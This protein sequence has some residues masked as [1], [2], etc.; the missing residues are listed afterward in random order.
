M[1]LTEI[2]SNVDKLKELWKGQNE[3]GN[4]F[5]KKY[6][7]FIDDV[8]TK[9]KTDIEDKSKGT[10][11]K[12]K[13][14]ER[15]IGIDKVQNDISMIFEKLNSYCQQNSTEQGKSK[16]KVETRIK[17]LCDE[18]YDVGINTFKLE[19]ENVPDESHRLKHRR[20]WFSKSLEKIS[21]SS[22]E[23]DMEETEEE[24]NL[25][26]EIEKIEKDLEEKKKRLSEMRDE[27]KKREKEEKKKY[28][29]KKE[30]NEEEEEDKKIGDQCTLMSR[31]DDL[32]NDGECRQAFELLNN[33]SLLGTKIL[34]APKS[35]TPRMFL[36]LPDPDK[37]PNG[38]KLN[39]WLNYKNWNK[40]VFNLHLLCECPGGIEENVDNETHLLETT[41]YS[42][43]DPYNLLSLFGPFLLY[44]IDIFM[45]SVGDKYP[46][47]VIKALGKTKPA[48]YFVSLTHEIQKVLKE[49]RLVH[50]TEAK[51][52]DALERYIEVSRSELETFLKRYDYSNMFGGLDKR[53]T[54][55]KKIRWVCP[56]HERKFK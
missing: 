14:R 42:I 46:R 12:K 18:I 11:S 20:S 37:C 45:E 47:E 44:S 55:D 40:N 48:D 36:I 3:N 8:V 51:N 31:I 30:K 50:K 38:A 32:V 19:L 39:Y 23:N 5:F 35:K 52:L 27:R 2:N 7:V 41:G 33:P 1:D 22:S 34:G 28:K 15:M 17:K 6:G 25:R 29:N 13:E 53:I 43:R 9:L 26:E 4:D 10:I 24:K 16:R 49:E 56:R 54:R 21:R